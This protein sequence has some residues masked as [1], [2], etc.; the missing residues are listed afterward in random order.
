MKLSTIILGLLLSTSLFA[1]DFNY[2]GRLTNLDGSPKVGPLPLKVFIEDGGGT[3]LCSYLKE[4]VP[5]NQGVFNLEVDFVGSEDPCVFVDVLKSNPEI[6]ARV[7]IMS[8]EDLAVEESTFAVQRL[9]HVP[10][11]KVADAVKD[12]GIS[13]AALN[14]ASGCEGKYVQVDGSGNFICSA[15]DLSSIQAQVTSNTNSIATNTSGISNNSTG[16]SNNANEIATKATD[17]E[18]QVTKTLAETSATEI[19]SNDTDITALQADKLNKTDVVSLDTPAVGKA[20]DSQSTVDRLDLVTTDLALK[21]NKTEVNTPAEVDSKIA[22]AISSQDFNDSATDDELTAGLDTKRNKGELLK[23]NETTGS[24]A[25]DAT[26]KESITITSP[27]EIADGKSYVLELPGEKGIENQALALD[28][29]GKLVW[30]SL[31]SGSVT[32]VTVSS[33]LAIDNTDPAR[34]AISIDLSSVEGQG[35]TN[36]SSITTL[37]ND[38][39]DKADVVGT[40]DAVA[41]KA[42][43][44]LSYTNA[45]NDLGVAVGTKAN[46]VDVDLSTVVDSKITSAVSGVNTSID[47]KLDKADV[48]L[49]ENA[50]SG[51]AADSLAVSNALTT[52]NSDIALK[53]NSSDVDT[54]AEVDSKI[55]AATASNTTFETKVK[56]EADDAATLQAAKDDANVLFVK[57]VDTISEANIA[58]EIAR[59]SEVTALLAGKQDI[60]ADLDPAITA[61]VDCPVGEVLSKVAGSLVC[62]TDAK[63]ELSVDLDA[64]V[65][66]TKAASAVDVQFKLDVINTTIAAGALNDGAVTQVKLAG[67]P[68]CA[69]GEAILANVD[70]SFRCGTLDIYKTDSTMRQGRPDVVFCDAIYDRA[71]GPQTFKSPY[72]FFIDKGNG[73]VEY[74][75]QSLSSEGLVQN[76]QID[77]AGIVT[78]A[79]ADCNG[80]TVAELISEGR[81]FSF[82]GNQVN[83][84]ASENTF[85]ARIKNLNGAVSI[86]SKSSDF[87]ESL[88]FL[89]KGNIRVK[90][91]SSVFTVMPSV[92]FSLRSISGNAGNVIHSFGDIDENELTIVLITENFNAGAENVD[93]NLIVQRQGSDY[94]DPSQI[95]FDNISEGAIVE[96]KINDQAVSGSKLKT[97]NGSPLVCPEGEAMTVNGAGEFLCIVAGSPDASSLTA[98]LLDIARIADDSIGSTKLDASVKASLAKADT[99]IQ[100][101]QNTQLSDADITELGYIKEFTEL[102]PT[103]KDFAKSDL[104]LCTEGQVLK[105][106][107]PVGALLCVADAKVLLSSD[108]NT[109]VDTNVAAGAV[110]VKAKL[111]VINAT[112]AVGSLN[113][114]SVTQVKLS[115]Q[116]TC[117]QDQVLLTN[118]DGSFKCGVIDNYIGNATVIN[119]VPDAI[120]CTQSFA[121]DPDDQGNIRIITLATKNANHNIYSTFAGSSTSNDFTVKYNTAGVF[122]G[123]VGFNNESW[124][125][126]R[127]GVTIAQLITEGKAQSFAGQQINLIASENT[128]S[129]H[130]FHGGTTANIMSQSKSFIQSV[131]HT[132]TGVV[133]IT[134][135][136]G[137]FT[138]APT[139]V[140]T[141]EE[142]DR[143]IG[144]RTGTLTKD[145]VVVETHNSGGT[146]FT[147][148]FSMIVQRQGNDYREPSEI[149]FDNISDNAIVESKINAQS[150]SGIKLKTGNAAQ[151]DCPAGQAITVNTAGE[152]SC[153]VAG[154]PDASELTTGILD[155]SRIADGSIAESKLNTVLVAK[156][157][158]AHTV[159][160]NLSEQNIID[161]GFIKTT[162]EIDPT[163]IPFAKTTLPTCAA[164]E[165]LKGDGTALSCVTDL[166]TKNTISDLG[167][168]PI[169]NT[170]VAGAKATF[171][172]IANLQTQIDANVVADNSIVESKLANNAVSQGKIKGITSCPSGEAMLSDGADGFVCGTLHAYDTNAT[173]ELAWPDAIRCDSST[174]SSSVSILYAAFTNADGSHSYH[175]VDSSVLIALK[176]N[177]DGSLNSTTNVGGKCAGKSIAENISE[178]RAFSFAG[179]QVNLIAS[180]NTFTARVISSA[181]ASTVTEETRDWI[182]SVSSVVNGI[183]TIT[184]KSG[185]FSTAPHIS[186]SLVHGEG[187]GVELETSDVGSINF[188]QPTKDSIK[189]IVSKDANQTGQTREILV[190]A[191][192]KGSDYRDP[193]Q[194]T[195]DNLSD[196]AIIASKIKIGDGSL[197]ECPAGQALT[198]I[199]NAGTKE[200]ACI[201]AG[202]PDAS[203]L[204]E[205]TV[206]IA[207]LDQTVQDSVTKTSAIE[208]N[209]D[210]TDTANVDAAGAVLHSDI[211][212]VSGV[213]KKTGSETYSAGLIIDADI[214]SI[215]IAKVTNLQSSLDSKIDDSSIPLC[216]TGEV[217]TRGPGPLLTFSCVATS[218]LELDTLLDGSGAGKAADAAA[219]ST[220]LDAKIS[221]VGHTD[222]NGISTN[223]VSGQILTTNPDGT[224]VCTSLAE[225]NTSSTIITSFPDVIRCSENGSGTSTLYYLSTQTTESV[226]YVGSR[227]T[228]TPQRIIYK[229]PNPASGSP[230]DYVSTTADTNDIFSCVNQNILSFASSNNAYSLA[231]ADR[232]KTVYDPTSFSVVVNSDGSLNQESGSW[233]DSIVKTGTGSYTINIKDGIFENSPNIVLSSNEPN[234]NALLN[235]VTKNVI[236]I[237]TLQPGVATPNQDRR[238]S[239]IATKNSSGITNDPN[240][241]VAVI[242]ANGSVIS[243]PSGMIGSVGSFSGGRVNLTFTS[244]FFTVTP[245]LVVD[246]LNEGNASNFGILDFSLTSSTSTHV[247]TYFNGDNNDQFTIYAQK[248]GADYAPTKEF[249]TTKT[250]YKKKMLGTAITNISPN[251][252]LSSTKFNN[253]TVGKTYRYHLSFSAVALDVDTISF[254]ASVCNNSSIKD[255]ITASMFNNNMGTVHT[256][257]L[258]KSGIFIAT[259]DNYQICYA[260]SITGGSVTIIEKETSLTLEEVNNFEETSDWD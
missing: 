67:Q 132:G 61:R 30:Q 86:L 242:A 121:T 144:Y 206:A 81:A 145:G 247:R 134:F 150:V 75:T 38:K 72:Y 250:K 77:T 186:G 254:G 70:G 156:I 18:Y 95:T 215:S 256:F 184:F 69:Q 139:A 162:S 218:N 78:D 220:A 245:N 43:D 114:G 54:K 234:R 124:D 87:I 48:V 185:F 58:S 252:T 103:V 24:E 117:L 80:K 110:D 225:F 240:I 14:L 15:V 82:A 65:D 198:I 106:V 36:A 248:V 155:T 200:F 207:R 112:I 130:V 2:Q 167:V 76:L 84:I 17:S 217:I 243:D 196:Q 181:S 3:V 177:P 42:A 187:V 179:N 214:A 137:F 194:I 93:L 1:S 211:S 116:P 161:F 26:L 153:I 129:A 205:G 241:S 71:G 216:G 118:E 154:S 246:S 164:G 163:V 62:V 19:N 260:G 182:E 127:P 4:G 74:M 108:L 83:L 85:S 189:F 31:S 210:V 253:L 146:T 12:G 219:V 34:P 73:Q 168:D 223:C 27:A 20:A 56:S 53:A 135:I 99:A 170:K 149:T 140:F 174:G 226:F 158:E 126:A 221:Q 230:G 169:D 201:E 55:A 204:T 251:G 79:E 45:L 51:K 96:S 133:S 191:Q 152:F 52:V 172:G 28:S 29:N 10:M 44:S 212:E 60:V 159:D 102:D 236:T 165:V 258:S 16:V 249:T 89:E 213:L 231:G 224:F 9:G 176:F 7:A 235:S 128:F 208:A 237:Q 209:A 147:E 197:V 37:Q 233:I 25:D 141:S 203:N 138:T 21:A 22:T 104:P 92:Q 125:C 239:V 175:G 160:T 91:K 120:K 119:S 192:R 232:S 11:A 255:N 199:D 113:D 259:D 39:L 66:A 88:E 229:G 115:G 228:T 151:L 64:E 35:A 123:Q 131:T 171:D 105:A 109:E 244:G 222:I 136:P 148:P 173:I 94:R 6:F 122:D 193:S 50:V 33:P 190:T 59:D 180:E 40:G 195:F 166:D 49:L 47:T 100:V 41:G 90:F 97:S 142:P 188:Y 32:E 98:G 63:V 57:K 101:D 107:G 178:G 227:G 5:L 202:S 13:P 8:S 111:D 68:S 157:N 183:G 143:M 23:L 238:F 46:S 257:N